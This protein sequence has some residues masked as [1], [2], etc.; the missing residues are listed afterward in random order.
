[1]TAD[2]PK[3]SRVGPVSYVF[4]LTPQRW[5]GDIPMLALV[6][7]I[8]QHA[9]TTCRIENTGKYGLLSVEMRRAY[10]RVRLGAANEA[11]AQEVIDKVRIALDRLAENPAGARAW[12]AGIL[13][14][15]STGPDPG[16][17]PP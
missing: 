4:E 10:I 1:M 2:K 11:I 6:P 14:P 13:V 12:L 15:T 9:I 17:A 16:G 8:V 7:A 5:H 3:P